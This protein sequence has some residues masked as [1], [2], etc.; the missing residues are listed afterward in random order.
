MGANKDG[1]FVVIVSSHL[2][3]MSKFW[4]MNDSVRRKLSFNGRER[5]P[6]NRLG[7]IVFINIKGRVF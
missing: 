3:R 2:A 5:T 7:V 4:A 6:Q 1:L